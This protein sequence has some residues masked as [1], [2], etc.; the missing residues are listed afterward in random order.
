MTAPHALDHPKASGFSF[1]PDAL[2]EIAADVLAHARR[3]G[4]SAAETEATE[5][6]GQTVTVRRGEVETIEYN[7]DKGVG[8]T[9]YLG[10][11]RGH[12]S[13]TDFSREA[14]LRTVEAALAIARYTG[15]DECAGLAD[16]DLLASDFPDLDL[17]HPWHLSV[18]EGIE[19]AR[20]CEAAALAVDPR[21]TNS[22]GAS[23][24]TH[25]YQFAYANSHGFIGGYPTSQHSIFCAVIGEGSDGMQRDD[26]YAVARDSR[27][28]DDPVAV[29]QK[30]GQRCAARLG[31][32]RI[33]TTLVPVLFE[34]PIA[35]SLIGHFVGAVSG[36]SLYRKSSFLL[37]SAGKEVFA[38]IVQLHERPFLKKGLRSAAF[39]D[40]GVATHD[41][42]VVSNGVVGGYFLGSYSARKL[43]LQSTGNA[44]GNHNLILDSTGEDFPTLLTR[45][46]TGLLVTDLLG[47]GV[48]SV[49]GDYSRGAAGFWVENGEIAYPVQEI[50]VAGNLKEMFRGIVAI[51]NDVVIRGARQCGSI[52]VERMTVAGE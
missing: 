5:G 31:A 49:T 42:E 44:G 2:R 10:H 4:A 30:A 7:R 27:D 20:S 40:E 28:L 12:A 45:L 9:V 25:Q 17:H 32:R 1:S 14:L 18:E 24:A 37:D 26:W 50:T 3:L 21:L 16:A 33:P 51:G 29:G 19:L 41:R 15:S 38:P 23:V 8:V 36:G 39:D 13:S 52:L 46:G 11:K 34:A 48:N 22:E 35:A 43:G 6:I 47:H